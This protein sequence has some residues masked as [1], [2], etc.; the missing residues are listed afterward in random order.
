MKKFIVCILFLFLM[1]LSVFSEIVKGEVFNLNGSS[2]DGVVIK[3]HGV[4]D[5]DLVFS[6]DKTVDGKFKFNVVPGLYRIFIFTEDTVFNSKDLMIRVYDNKITRIRVLLYQGDGFEIV[7]GKKKSGLFTI[8]AVG[9]GT[10]LGLVKL[11]DT[12]RVYSP[13]KN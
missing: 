8:F 12:L 10:I 13:I 2:L 5:S 3:L 9:G 4:I 6:S 7:D 11:N 1:Q